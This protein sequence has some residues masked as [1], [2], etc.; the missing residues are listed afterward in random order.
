MTS[1]TQP[2]A[3]G[4]APDVDLPHDAAVP[5][6]AEPVLDG[7][8][9]LP[10][11]ITRTA[12]W[13]A[14]ASLISEIGIIVTGGAVRLTKSGLGCPTWP[15]C[16]P[17][18]LTNTPEMGIHGIIEFGN[19]TLTFVL[20][21]IALAM[22]LWVWRMRRS[23]P[24]LFWMSFGLLLGIPAQAVVGGITVLTQLN[25]WVVAGHFMVS[26]TMVCVATLLVNRVG[27]E[28]R[29]RSESG[30]PPQLVD[31]PTTPLSR[32]LAW[33][34]FISGWAAVYLGTVVTGTGPHGGDATAPRH[35][36]DPLIVTRI[37]VVPV[38]IMVAAAVLLMIV[39]LRQ[40]S[41]RR[42]RISIVRVLMV[43]LFQGLIGY[44]QHF[45]GLPILLVLLHMLGAALIVWAMTNALDRQRST[46]TARVAEAVEAGPEQMA[47]ARA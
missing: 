45:N 8:R 38:Y 30:T 15:K 24:S 22:L 35:D 33:V 46:Y 4:T 21:F 5:R 28:W 32:G 10:S 26:A 16:T 7:P 17:E 25:P 12:Y 31:G 36:F 6:S 14:V 37:H 19:R 3:V 43:V 41:S 42:Q 1:S 44:V 39:V 40:D 13:L 29:V 9:W 34:V 18:S 2:A 47:Q 27:L 20:G 23:H 11:T